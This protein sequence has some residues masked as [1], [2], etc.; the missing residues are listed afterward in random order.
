MDWRLKIFC[1]HFG[2]EAPRAG[3]QAAQYHAVNIKY[4]TQNKTTQYC[5]NF[6]LKF[7]IHFPLV[8]L[9]HVLAVLHCA[10]WQGNNAMTRTA[11]VL[12]EQV[13]EEGNTEI[14]L[15]MCA[16]RISARLEYS[17][18]FCQIISFLACSVLARLPYSIA[19]GLLMIHV[20]KVR[21]NLSIYGFNKWQHIFVIKVSELFAGLPSL[22][23]ERIWIKTLMCWTLTRNEQPRGALWRQTIDQAHHQTYASSRAV[24]QS[25]G[26]L[27]TLSQ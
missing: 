6:S 14:Q 7:L 17:E 27:D 16:M 8:F 10:C 20:L 5:S 21:N 26:V 4:S 12:F 15:P 9:T 23:Q 13:W 3:R 22:D 18:Q 2:V 24:S 1:S 25:G 11:N 19:T